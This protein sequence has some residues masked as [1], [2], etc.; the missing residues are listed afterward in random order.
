LGQAFAAQ[1]A[2]NPRLQRVS[3]WTTP[4]GG[5]PGVNASYPFAIE[6]YFPPLLP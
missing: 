1:A 3:F 5:G 4:D 6:D 2:Q